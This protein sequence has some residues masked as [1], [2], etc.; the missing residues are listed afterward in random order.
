MKETTSYL[1]FQGCESPGTVND[2]YCEDHV[3]NAE[4]NYDGG[5]WA[6]DGGGDCCGSNV[7]IRNCVECT[8]YSQQFHCDGP[9]EFISDGYCNDETNNADCNYDGGDCC[10]GCANIDHCLNC[11]CYAESPIDPYCK[12]INIYDSF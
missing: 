10:G 4:C 3:N 5:I 2:G 11:V 1:N 9:E 6:M 12:Y 7:N 8:C